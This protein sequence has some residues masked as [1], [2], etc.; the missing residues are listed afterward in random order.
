MADLHSRYIRGNLAFWD[1]HRKRLIDAIGPDVYK[2]LNDW[3]GED[4]ISN[5]P[6]GWTAT[7]VGSSTVA[8]SSVVGG[9][10]LITTGGTEDNGISLQL[11]SEPFECTADQDVYFGIRLKVSEATQADFLVGLCVT[12]TALL[13]GVADGIYFE[14]V[15]GGTGISTV[16]EKSN[17]ETQS[18]SEGTVVAGTYMLLE[19]YYSGADDSVEFFIDGTSVTVPAAT[20]IPDDVTLTP[21]IEFLTGD[22]SAETM[23]VD[24]LRVI[25]IGR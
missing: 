13:G 24:W 15:D 21:S 22:T 19:F 6:E 17:S 3:T 16:V 18:D 12:D 8:V 7:L 14:S 25:A 20:N 5:A 2:Y 9:N 10:L 23:D 11:D 1:T 4:V